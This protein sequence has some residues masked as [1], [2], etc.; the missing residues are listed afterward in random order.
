[1]VVG[2]D[3]AGAVFGTSWAAEGIQDSRTGHTPCCL[4]HPLLAQGHRKAKQGSSPTAN[5]QHE[6][7]WTADS[8]RGLI[9]Q[10]EVGVFLNRRTHWPSP[11]IQRSEEADVTVL[12]TLKGKHVEQA[13][14]MKQQCTEEN[15]GLESR[16]QEG[17]HLKRSTIGHRDGV[18]EP[19]CFRAKQ[20]PS[21][22]RNN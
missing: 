6:L 16:K 7:G 8:G 5:V 22:P 20:Y 3:V 17:A 4:W 9:P 12:L 2:E 10:E 18:P 1:M 14:W 21:R 15:N 13:R 11:S 19:T